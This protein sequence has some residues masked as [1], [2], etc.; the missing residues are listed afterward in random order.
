MRIARKRILCIF[1]TLSMFL[2]LYIPCS[3]LAPQAAEKE[4]VF[5]LL[6]DSVAD[7]F[8]I[9][10]RDDACYGRI[11]A[12]TDGYR[13]Y[14]LGVTGMTSTQLLKH[15]DSGAVQD[16]N[17]G[18]NVTVKDYIRMADIICISIGANDYF[19]RPDGGLLAMGAILGVGGKTFDK[20]TDTY[21]DNLCKILAMIDDLNADVPVIMQTYY[22]VWN[23]IAARPNKILAERTLE[24]LEKYDAAHPGRIHICDISPAMNGKP[25][26]LADDCLH[27]NAKG[28]VAI[29]EIILQKLYDLGLG[30]ETTPVAGVPGEDWNVVRHYTK[31]RV[32]AVAATALLMLFTGN[33]VNIPRLF[34]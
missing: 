26:N 12:D 23:G 1:L 8:G 21:Y 34:K 4:P 19:N 22:L 14:N 6:G 24:T 20:I 13:Y 15:I 17:T 11:V 18:K 29:A 25:E 7:A 2:T 31:S 10:N 32:L 5:L 3:A 27:P 28:N 30:T 9:A 33:S 16:K